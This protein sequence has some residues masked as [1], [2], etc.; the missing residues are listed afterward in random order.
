MASHEEEP[1][2]GD[3]VTEVPAG[4]LEVQPL[5]LGELQPHPPEPRCPASRLAAAA[6]PHLEFGRCQLPV[7][8][9]RQLGPGML[10][11]LDGPDDGGVRIMLGDTLMATGQLVEVAGQMAVRV[12]RVAS[13]GE[14]P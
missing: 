5:C 4:S 1:L 3:A 2:R 12:S 8:E 9:A 7:G 6:A 14:A 10:L 11:A 13:T